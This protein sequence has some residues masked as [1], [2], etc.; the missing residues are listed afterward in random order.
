LRLFA[1]IAR[2]RFAMVGSGQTWVHPIY[3]EDVVDGL[4][5][6]ATLSK[7]IGQTYLLAGPEP[8]RLGQLVALIAEL[9]GVT[10]PRLAI[11]P[12][13]AW[14]AAASSEALFRLVRR[15]PPLYR[16]Q[17][18]FFLKDQL[19]STAKAR[20]ELGFAPATSLREGLARTIA[21]YRDHG[22]LA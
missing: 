19:F 9:T 18:D 1:S 22:L 6:C 15:R 17:L 5:R 10:P 21:W 12:R 4:L 8:V 13:L 20:D 16:R 14:L 2:R 7:A 3:V 11:P